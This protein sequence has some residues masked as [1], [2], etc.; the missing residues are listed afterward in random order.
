MADYISALNGREM[1]EALMDMAQHNS[2]AWAVGERKAV[3]V[4]TG[5]ETYHNN[6]KYYAQL[7]KQDADRAEAA[8]VDLQV[9]EQARNEAVAAKESIQNMTVS[10]RTLSAGRPATVTKTEQ[11]GVVNLDFGIPQ[12]EAG[13][14]GEGALP[15]GGTT[16]QALVKLSDADGDVGWATVGG[17]GGGGGCRNILDNAWFTVNQ[18]GE[19]GAQSASGY[20]FDRWKVNGGYTI[21]LLY[22]LTLTGTMKQYIEDVLLLGGLTLTASVLLYTDHRVISGTITR[23]NGTSQEF[24]SEDGFSAAFDADGG[25]TVTA[26]GGTIRAVKLEVGSASTILTESPPNYAVEL[27]KCKRFL[28]IISQDAGYPFTSAE[29]TSTRYEHAY[30]LLS[31]P[32]QIEMYGSPICTLDGTLTLTSP[33]VPGD[34]LVATSINDTRKIGD[35]L[36]LSIDCYKAGWENPPTLSPCLL[37]LNGSLVISSESQL[38]GGTP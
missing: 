7:A 11:G 25:F 36:V 16:G 32:M 31:L 37:T 26:A 24:F 2:E 5:D 30:V 14:P 27:V 1:D 33:I 12:G 21:D 38:E 20:A 10:S 18:R 34:E 6:A 22:G 9:V 19:A 29:V 28:N 35:T 3:P 15:T 13:E 23:V 4:G 8:Q 17:G